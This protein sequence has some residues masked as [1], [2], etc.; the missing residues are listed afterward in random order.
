MKD[1]IALRM[2]EA[3]E[4][5]G[6]LQPGGT[7][8]EP[9][10]RQ[11]RRRAGDGRPAQGLPVRL[12]LPG[13]GQRGQAQRAQGVRR[14]GRRLPDRGRPGP[15][16]LLLQRVR[17][18][19]RARSTAPGSPTSTPTRTT[20]ESHYET[21]G[22]EI[23]EQTDGRITHFVAGIGTGGT[24]SG[25]GRYLKEVVRRAG[26]GDRRRPGG[27]GVLRRH[28]PAL[29]R[30]GRRRGL[31][32]RHLRPGHRRP[33]HR[34]LRRRLVRD[35][36]AAGPRGGAAGRRLVRDGRRSPRCGWPRELARGRRRRRAAARRRPRLPVKVFND[37][38]M[39]GYGFL[40]PADGRH[41]RR[42]AAPQG[43][44]DP[45]ARA[46]PPERDRRRGRPLSCASTAS[47]RCRWSGPS[48]R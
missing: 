29:P 12:R 10:S 18:A 30:R 20:R 17:P 45:R 7:I 6:E 4:A 23:W 34:G 19:G 25:T 2:I 24:I 35:D 43:R 3:A 16:R 21:T 8:V 11:H 44:R 40:P 41:G 27:L 38:W 28:R 14:R 47:P 48:R 42:R 26:P 31:L 5:S 1:R 39:A 46:R 32:A 9:T 33:D 37:E 22:P 36:P 13:Q 15:P